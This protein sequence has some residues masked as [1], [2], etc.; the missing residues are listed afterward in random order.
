MAIRKEILEVFRNIVAHLLARIDGMLNFESKMTL[1][2][3]DPNDVENDIILGDDELADAL[4]VLQRR[5]NDEPIIGNPTK[6]KMH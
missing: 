6:G 4:A 1:I 3:R 2:I 5:M